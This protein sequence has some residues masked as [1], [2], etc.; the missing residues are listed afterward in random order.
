MMVQE[1]HLLERDTEFENIDQILDG[2]ERTS[3]RLADSFNTP[4]IDI[5]GLSDEWEAVKKEAVTIPVS[6]LPHPSRLFTAWDQLK[7]EA[8]QQ[9]CSTFQISSLMALSVV[10]RFPSRALWLSQCFTLAATRT[11]QLFGHRLLED[12]SL[13]LTEI[14]KAG[15]LRYWVNE[16]APYLKAAASHFSPRH[17]S[18]TQHLIAWCLEKA[19]T[20]RKRSLR[21]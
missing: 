5:E 2:L 19:G 13:S 10:K 9:G 14:K 20:V 16:L 11:G 15:Y 7:Q 21:K 8:R 17:T 12:Y 1:H 4:P 18:Y 3:A 6:Q